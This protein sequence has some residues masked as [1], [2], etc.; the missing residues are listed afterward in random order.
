MRYLI[1][2]TDP[3]STLLT[4]VL[5]KYNKAAYKDLIFKIVPE[6]KQ[7]NFIGQPISEISYFIKLNFSEL[8]SK[9]YGEVGIVYTIVD[10]YIVIESSNRD[11]F[12]ELYRRVCPVKKGVPIIDKK[13]EFKLNLLTMGI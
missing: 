2:L 10:N 9:I 7:G 1:D 4:S 5:K 8:F 6:L 3:R 13:A 11:L 12:F